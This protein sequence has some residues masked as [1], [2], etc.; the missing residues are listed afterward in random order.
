M[1]HVYKFKVVE[2]VEQF[3][4][5]EADDF[6]IAELLAYETDMGKNPDNYELTAT[7]VEEWDEGDAFLPVEINGWKRYSND[8]GYIYWKDYPDHRTVI[9]TVWLDTVEGDEG[10]NKEHDCY[11][12]ALANDGNIKNGIPEHE[13]DTLEESIECWNDYS[14]AITDTVR[15]EAVKEWLLNYMEEN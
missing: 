11:C 5:I 13:W 9:G 14:Q 15:W 2:H 10:Y 7:L 3:V 8:G 1:K 4:E 12:V 6:E